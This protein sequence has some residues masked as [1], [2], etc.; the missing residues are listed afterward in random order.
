MQTTFPKA[1][2]KIAISC[3]RHFLEFLHQNRISVGITTYQTNRL[4]LLGL[5][6]D[7]S[8]STF[9]RLFDRPMGLYADSEQLL[10]ATRFQIW[11]LNNI[12][13][14]D[15]TDNG[16]D[17]LFVPRI[18]Y[19]TGDLDIHDL[20]LTGNQRP[21]FVNTLYSCL[22]TVSEKHSFDV[23]WQPP[24]ISRLL[25][26]DRCHL[27]GL[28]M[29]D[30]KARYVTAVSRSDVTA[31]WRDRREGGGV[32]ID[33]ANNEIVCDGLSMPH[34]P[35]LYRGKLWLLNAGT[36]E[37]GQVDRK[38][39]RFQPLVF[40]PG[41]L[42]GLA[43]Y[44]RFALVAMSLP[45]YNKV[46]SGL[47]LDETLEKKDA[48]PFCGIMVVDLESGMTAHWLR[49]EGEVVTE[50]YDVQVLP[51]VRC[52][53]ML[54]FVNDQ[55]KRTISFPDQDRIV[56]HTLMKAESD[57]AEAAEG[58]VAPPT[59]RTASQSQTREGT[60]LLR[61]QLS[62]QELETRYGGL[63]FPSVGQR[64]AVQQLNEPLICSLVID[65]KQTVALIVAEIR[66]EGKALLI[67]L[68]VLPPYRGKGVA[69][70]LLQDM[71][72]QLAERGLTRLSVYYRSNWSS[73]V[74]FER[75]LQKC[76]WQE[77]IPHSLQ[78]R[79]DIDH[80]SKA[81]WVQKMRLPPEF[82]L[83]PWIEL[84]SE[85]RQQIQ[86]RND[87]PSFLTPFQEE[88][89]ISWE[90][91]FGLR[92]DGRVIGWVITHRTKQDTMQYTTLVIEP[93]HRHAACG[94]G[95]LAAAIRRQIEMKIPYFI[96]MVNEGNN[97]G[98]NLSNKR[99]RPFLISAVETRLSSKNLGKL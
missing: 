18:G 74:G 54:G 52:P 16:Y 30:G 19:T 26:E 32:L 86:E 67:S 56:R 70:R 25:P 39:G 24:F 60:A 77:P 61:L 62:C 17:R 93:G 22:S 43:F 89:R 66:E 47:P 71:E 46:F 14:R 4:F 37:L 75:V 58:T 20:T 15:E 55:I 98:L 59:Q 90:T 94:L 88:G 82:I 78:C 42:R 79:T 97:A 73:L 57:D 13:D 49:F 96:F 5:K 31:G 72:Q 23:H 21:L 64:L 35:R 3:S 95:L 87:Y 10:L 9:E 68:M 91:S 1:G 44:D 51:G 83:F 6:P 29:E 69:T 80:I 53:T 8:L 76:G 38:S 84:N 33:V 99:I 11:Q 45:R 65:G 48:K 85:E 34:S 41:Y 12:L 7:N 36:G 28:A 50:L 81:P 27:N 63:T 92:K 40:C 2:E